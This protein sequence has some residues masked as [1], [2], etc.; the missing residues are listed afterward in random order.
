VYIKNNAMLEPTK[1]IKELQIIKQFF[2]DPT[3][4]FNNH[5]VSAIKNSTGDAQRD[6]M[7]VTIHLHEQPVLLQQK[8]SALN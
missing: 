4:L 3:I 6:L 7:V 8:C 5:A 2:E 1:D